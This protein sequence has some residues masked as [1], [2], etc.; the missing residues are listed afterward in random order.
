[1]RDYFDLTDRQLIQLLIGNDDH[2]AFMEI[3]ARYA[4]KLHHTGSKKID[5][6]EDIKDLIQEVFMALW[7]NRRSLTIDTPL[8][9][10]L[11]ATM[12]YIIIKRIAHKKVQ[13]SYLDTLDPTALLYDYTST[14]TLVRENELKHLIENEISSLPEKMQL[15][16]RMSRQDHLTHKE[17]ASELGL[18]E[19]TVKKHVN[20]ALKSLRVRLGSLLFLIC[21]YLSKYLF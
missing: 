16:F 12:R 19:A 17:I 15:V 7:N 9:G 14:D 21:C 20:N 13:N 1:M 10:Y 3:Y 6:R 2:R 18:S 11:F 4:K 5:E 8:G